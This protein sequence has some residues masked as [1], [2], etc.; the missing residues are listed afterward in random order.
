MIDLTG[1]TDVPVPEEVLRELAA[2]CRDAG[3]DCLVIGAAA[4]DLV[5]H[6]QQGK[7]PIRATKESTSRSQSV[8]TTS[9]G[10]SVADSTA[11]A[12]HRIR[13]LCSVSRSTSSPSAAMK[14]TV[15]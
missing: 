13:S 8:V 5:I 14:P 10:I 1:R 9:S 2:I 4:R 12:G 7:S 6:T 11:E 3:V 15:R